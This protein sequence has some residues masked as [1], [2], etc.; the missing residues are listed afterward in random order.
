GLGR[1]VIHGDV[2]DFNV[3]VDLHTSRVTGIVDFGD[4]VVSETVNDLAIAMAYTALGKADPVGAACLVA[5]GYHAIRPLSEDEIAVLFAL[6]ATRLCL[7]VTVAAAQ[8]AERPDNDYLGI[9]QAPIRETLPKLAAVHPR[10]AHYRL[11]E[12]C[13][14]SPVPHT[15]RVVDYL[16]SRAGQF[17][18]VTEFDLSTDPVVG[19]DLSV[20]STLVASNPADDAPEPFG[21]RLFD[22]IKRAGAVI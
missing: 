5:R 11:R 21:R 19:I 17:A 2:N 10:L 6:M 18:G 16:R 9:S 7:S 4:M 14:L 22:V 20:G 8:Q 13:G 12:A 3:L 1:S 15:P